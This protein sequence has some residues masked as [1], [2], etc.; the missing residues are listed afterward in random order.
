[1]TAIQEHSTSAWKTAESYK[2]TK[3]PARRE[4]EDE[5]KQEC[6]AATVAPK[7]EDKP[8]VLL[9]VNCRSIYSKALNF[10]NL[11]DTYNL[12]L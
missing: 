11:T 3:N 4:N 1:M 10:W 6:L 9:L 7:I 2:V 12:M 5:T 8:F